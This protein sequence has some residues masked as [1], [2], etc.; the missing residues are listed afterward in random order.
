M[1][2]II[3]IIISI[4]LITLILLQQRGSLGGAVFGAGTSEVFLKRRGVEGLIFKLTWVF[5]ILFLI[6]SVIRILS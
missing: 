3:I 6:F 5:F 4:I 2:D 1:L